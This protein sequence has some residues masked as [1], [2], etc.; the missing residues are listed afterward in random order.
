MCGNKFFEAG[1]TICLNDGYAYE[2]KIKRWQLWI[3]DRDSFKH[4]LDRRIYGFPLPDKN[5]HAVYTQE[6]V[7]LGSV[8]H[9]LV[10][11]TVNDKAYLA[12]IRQY[13][14]TQSVHLYIELDKEHGEA[15]ITASITT[16]TEQAA[17]LNGP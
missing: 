12:K 14:K 13:S 17:S 10:F 3:A 8:T 6:F 1:S 7:T 4:S 9:G 5:Q 16:K 2:A 15:F 11:R